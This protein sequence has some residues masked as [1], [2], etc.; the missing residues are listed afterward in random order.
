MTYSLSTSGDKTRK[1]SQPIDSMTALESPLPAASS[2]NSRASDTQHQ[3]MDNRQEQVFESEMLRSH[4]CI[5]FNRFYAIIKRKTCI[6]A[7]NESKSNYCLYCWGILC[8]VYT[9]ISIR[10]TRIIHA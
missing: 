8:T 2:T 4:E 3:L 10:F 9:C 7:I 5:K 6:P 1:V